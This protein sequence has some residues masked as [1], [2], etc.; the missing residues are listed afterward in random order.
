MIP[1]FE[2]RIAIRLPSEQRQKIDALV[3]EGKFQNLSHLVRE[4]LKQF[5]EKEVEKNG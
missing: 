4:A 3:S 1:E 5:L 2:K